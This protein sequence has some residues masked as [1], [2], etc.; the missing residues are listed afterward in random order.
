MHDDPLR[1]S[2]WK[3]LGSFEIDTASCVFG[4]GGV[5]NSQAH[6]ERFA[7]GR[8]LLDDPA[9]PVVEWDIGADGTLVLEVTQDADGH[10][11]AARLGWPEELGLPGTWR[12]VSNL[13]ITTG[14]C[15]V[16][17]PGCGPDEHRL[18]FAAPPGEYLVEEYWLDDGPIESSGFRMRRATVA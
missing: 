3:Q 10:I 5:V 9:L 4:D 18:D 11:S 2:A 12:P 1:G 16:G 15:F 14:Q 17:D 6:S 13:T 7:S 8:S